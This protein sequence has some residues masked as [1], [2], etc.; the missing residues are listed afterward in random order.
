[1]DLYL[2]DRPGA[3]PVVIWL[4]GGAW[5]MGDKSSAPYPEKAVE[6]GL[7][8]A[9]VSYRYSYEEHFPGQLLDCKAAVRWL[10]KH[11]DIYGIHPDRIGVWG[12]SAGGHL[13]ALLGVTGHT[14]EFD[15]GENTAFSSSVQAVC[16]WYGPTD[17][18]LMNSQ[19][20]IPGPISNDDADSPESQLIGG[21]I[22]ENRKKTARANP[23]NYVSPETPPF[24]IVHGE[25]DNLVPIGQS[26]ILVEALRDAGVAVVYKTLPGVGHAFTGEV[27]EQEADAALDFFSDI[28]M[29]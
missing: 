8:L 25:L 5:R 11:A 4:F 27:R 28:F 21:P 16:D 19:R 17:F 2:P 3:L 6:Q 26:E 18:L 15:A 10:R 9:S 13:A 12:A 23:V 24:R 20:T 29:R 7:I 22:Q 14:R 1:M